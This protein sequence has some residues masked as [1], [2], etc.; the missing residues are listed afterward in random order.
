MRK[1]SFGQNNPSHIIRRHRQELPSKIG[2]LFSSEFY[3]INKLYSEI[4]TELLGV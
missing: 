1:G 4:K 3:T 2:E